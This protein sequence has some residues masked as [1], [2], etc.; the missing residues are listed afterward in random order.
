MAGWFAL[1]GRSLAVFRVAVGLC[2][3]A[4]LAARAV[5]LHD[6]YGPGGV[7]PAGDWAGVRA[8]L[9]AGGQPWYWPP[10]PLGWVDSAAWCG[11]WLAATGAAA[12]LFCC[13]VGTRW[14]AVGCWAG[15]ACVHHRLPPVQYGANHLLLATLLWCP[16]LPWPDVPAGFAAFRRGGDDERTADPPRPV[17]NGG[18]VALALQFA[19]VH[20]FTGL[21]KTGEPWRA[22]GD[23][24]GRALTLTDYRTP[25]GAAL[26]DVLAAAPP[27][28][29]A[30]TWGTL[31]WELA[32]PITLILAGGRPRLRAAAV[33][34]FLLLH[35]GIA[36]TMRVGLFPA[37]AS[38]GALAFLPGAAW[39]RLAG[40]PA[41]NPPPAVRP[42]PAAGAV[43]AL[44]LGL[45][46]GFLNLATLPG[47]NLPGTRAF[48]GLGNATG[49]SQRWGMF[50]PEPAPFDG[51]LRLVAVF[52]DG[53]EADLPV[54]TDA[55][56][57]WGKLL[58]SAGDSPTPG[59]GPPLVRWA[60]KRAGG[61]PPVR[62]DLRRRGRPVLGTA[63]RGPV[64]EE[65]VAAWAAPDWR[66]APT[67]LIRSADEPR[68][69]GSR[70]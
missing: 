29:A 62:V 22:G 26:A 50:A 33:C 48:G 64:T 42:L 52:A 35:A 65:T 3:L 4:D 28:N 14:A 31:A 60:V 24:V 67:E 57:R 1:D 9:A 70:P 43:A 25:A 51:R 53:A 11:A 58:A 6:W 8:D 16:F 17:V 27:L 15:L 56:G 32:G 66:A 54:P 40:R 41:A 30:L 21:Q 59:V 19:A 7:L 18:T 69:S 44:T 23:A 10:S 36:V 55:L 63:R 47:W 37:V 12:G 38:A 68:P 39:D 61:D 13:G 46:C 20:V 49:L 45:A 5:W 2:V 34:G